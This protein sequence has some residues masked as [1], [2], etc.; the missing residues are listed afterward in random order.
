MAGS[1]EH[2]YALACQA[3][4]WAGSHGLDTLLADV[5]IAIARLAWQG[6]D[7]HGALSELGRAWPDVAAMGDAIQMMRACTLQGLVHIDLD[8]PDAAQ[9]W[10]E[11]ALVQAHRSGR[12][13]DIATAAANLPLPDL[14]RARAALDRAELEAMRSLYSSTL[15]R[16]REAIKQATESGHTSARANSLRNLA[17]AMA[18]LGN[19]DD[20]GNALDEDDRVRVHDELDNG[21]VKNR[22]ERVRLA[23]LKCDFVQA[24]HIFASLI[25]LTRTDTNLGLVERIYRIGATLAEQRGD[26]EC[27]LAR[28]KLYHDAQR[29]AS[30]ANAELSA[31]LLAVR[32]ETS[33]ARAD[34]ERMR[35]AAHTDALTSLLNRRALDERLVS[36]HAEART[37]ATPMCA[38][39]LD[40]D[41]FKRVND[42]FGHAIGDAVL[43]RVGELLAAAC[44]DHDVVG[45]WGGEEFLIVASGI[46]LDTSTRVIE[47]LRRRLQDEHW[48]LVAPGL[49]VTASFGVAD[50]SRWASVAEA[51]YRAK[52]GGR[53]RVEV[54]VRP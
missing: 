9:P 13:R 37:K 40:I 25:E 20:A 24:E 31:R 2:A 19:W 41:H 38:A 48:G 27:A 17:T 53:N 33:H 18:H 30:K 10:F 39:L 43:K 5:R 21:L 7:I 47:R 11:T 14:K 12:A 52:H 35:Q 36:M 16:L 42:H 4:R 1:L 49:V 26:F 3:E 15:G 46:D 45:R 32:L 50:F 8:Q 6:G 44:R 28:Y 23:M 51:L 29:R 54:V 34:A 22:V